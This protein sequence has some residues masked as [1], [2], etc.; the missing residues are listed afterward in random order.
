V[1]TDNIRHRQQSLV[2]ALAAYWRPREYRDVYVI[3][4]E[5]ARIYWSE[6]YSPEDFMT[7]VESDCNRIGVD[8]GDTY[9]VFENAWSKV[10]HP[11]TA[12]RQTLA[13]CLAKA[14]E[15]PV[16]LPGGANHPSALLNRVWSLAWHLQ[17][18]NGR[19]DILLPQKEIATLFGDVRLQPRVSEAIQNLTNK[20]FLELREKA[21]N[22]RGKA[23][24]YRVPAYFDEPWNAVA[25]AS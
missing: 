15:S 13:E 18:H 14:D 4:L 19:L 21:N 22:L 20:G 10:R 24:K 9:V 3:G 6:N 12:P 2:E 25:V 11:K 17:D 16:P 23:A 8:Y 5:L 7:A 1:H